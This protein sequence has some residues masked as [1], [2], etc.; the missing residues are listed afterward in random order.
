MTDSKTRTAQDSVRR[1]VTSIEVAARAGV[2][3]SAVSRSFSAGASVSDATRKKVMRAARELSYRPNAIARTLSTRQSNIIGIVLSTL[4]NQL[5]PVVVEQLSRALQLQGKHT[6]LF[7]AQKQD[8]DSVFDEILS[9]QLDGVVIASAT[10][11]SKLSNQCAEM[12]IPVVMFNRATD[13]TST[14]SVTSD[15]RSAGQLVGQA[16]IASGHQRIAY[17]SGRED[18]STN[19]DRER[20]LR[21]VL[22]A[23][24]AELFARANGNYEQA[25]ASAAAAQ[26]MSARLKPDAIV[27]A[28]DHMAFAVIDTL[29]YALNLNVP[30]DVSVVGFDDVP[31]SAWLA[32]QLTTVAQSVEKMVRATVELLMNPANIGQGISRNV[33]VACELV[34][35][36]SIAQR[37]RV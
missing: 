36:A 8:T 33:V 6:M 34:H 10:L 24:G 26:L 13:G 35:R 30:R 9:Y 29:R 3:Q 27:V 11:S 37:R 17:I 1:A 2:S 12:G 31:Q 23:S 22:Q 14:D 16:L 32:Y 18:S 5:Y 4:E 21:E 25:H 19:R 15:N 28:S 7:L 20:G